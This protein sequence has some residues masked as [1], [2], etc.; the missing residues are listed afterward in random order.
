MGRGASRLF[1]CVNE[2]RA[3]FHTSPMPP[4]APFHLKAGIQFNAAVLSLG[5]LLKLL[6]PQQ[7]I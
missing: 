4:P 3:G 5:M 2:D 1:G 6:P 7:L